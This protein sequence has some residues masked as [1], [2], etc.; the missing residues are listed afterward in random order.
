MLFTLLRTLTLRSKLLGNHVP[1]TLCPDF[2]SFTFTYL[3]TYNKFFRHHKGFRSHGQI[4]ANQLVGTIGFEPIRLST[5]ERPSRL[6]FRHATH[7]GLASAFK[8]TP[9][10]CRVVS[11]A[12]SALN[13]RHILGEFDIFRTIVFEH[14]RYSAEHLNISI[15]ISRSRFLA[16]MGYPVNPA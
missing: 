1:T 2:V 9:V 15:R 12:T 11:T 13:N 10:R 3:I 14:N 7:L 8:Y 4:F 5:R 6:P 16:I